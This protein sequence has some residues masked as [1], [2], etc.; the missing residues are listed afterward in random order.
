MTRALRTLPIHL[1]LILGAAIMAFPFFWMITSSFK[2]L[3]EASSVPPVWFPKAWQFQNYADVFKA[4]PFGRYFVNSIIVGVST[5]VL[6]LVTGVLAAYAFARMHFKGRTLVFLIFLGTMM[7]PFEV[8]IVPEFVIIQKLHWYN[9]Y[10]GRSLLLPP[11]PSPSSCSASSLPAFPMSC[12]KP[13][14]WTVRAISAFSG[15]LCCPSR[16]RRWLP[17]AWSLSWP[18]GTVSYGRLS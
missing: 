2:T 1:V 10:Q 11:A 15:E 3:F 14:R 12:T 6:D 13:L 16:V 18:A 5:M 4:A 9:T 7:V 17:P 8:L